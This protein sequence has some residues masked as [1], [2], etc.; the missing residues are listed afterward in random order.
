MPFH[1]YMRRRFGH[2]YDAGTISDHSSS[3]GE[4][5]IK[6]LAKEKE[7]MKKMAGVG[8]RALATIGTTFAFGTLDGYRET[9]AADGVTRVS[10]IPTI[11]SE[12]ISAD[13]IAGLGFHAL[14]LYGKLGESG[15]AMAESAGNGALA[16]YAAHWGVVAGQAIKKKMDERAAGTSAKGVDELT[17]GGY[18]EALTPE[19]M[20][21]AQFR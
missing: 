3:E 7:T 11:G 4:R 2:G 12:Y 8:S 16:Y 6:T 19:Q 21:Q 17:E 14:A 18:R 13:L 5:A 20:F 10:G 1:P 9:K 15:E